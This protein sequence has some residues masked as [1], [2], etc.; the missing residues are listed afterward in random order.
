M[1]SVVPIAWGKGGAL[2]LR[3]CAHH[4][5]RRFAAPRVAPNGGRV[6]AKCSDWTQSP[7][8]LKPQ[9]QWPVFGTVKTVP[10]QHLKTGFAIASRQMTPTNIT[11]RDASNRK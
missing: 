1:T 5:A 10:L 9:F 4:C 8:R 11:D 7:Q 2:A 3:C 6:P